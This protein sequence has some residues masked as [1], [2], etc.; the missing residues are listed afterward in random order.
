MSL[1]ACHNKPRSTAP[2]AGQDGWFYG[3]SG[4]TRQPRIIQIPQVLSRD[5]KYDLRATDLQCAGCV[6][7]ASTIKETA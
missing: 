2:Y 6:H 1:Y 7:I 4:M 5:C 3:A